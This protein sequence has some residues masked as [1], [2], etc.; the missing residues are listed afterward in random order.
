MNEE[1]EEF[2]ILCQKVTNSNQKEFEKLLHPLKVFLWKQQLKQYLKAILIFA[3]ICFTLY[4][5]D[6]LNWYFCAI[7]RLAMIKL[8]PVWNWT[9]LEKARCLIAKTEVQKLNTG[10]LSSINDKDC[11]ACE[12]Y[13]RVFKKIEKL[14]IFFKFSLQT[15]LMFSKKQLMLWFMTNS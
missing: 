5:V 11:R 7:G 6:T 4:Y 2:F 3:A 1:F 10:G 14:K 12:H 8:L 9:H 13:G 15:K